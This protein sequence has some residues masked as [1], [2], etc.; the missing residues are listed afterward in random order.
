M[1]L[2]LRRC[3]FFLA[4]HLGSSVAARLGLGSPPSLSLEQSIASLDSFGSDDS[5]QSPSPDVDIT[6]ESVPDAEPGPAK[7]RPVLGALLAA[8][9]EPV[10]DAGT[11]DEL[12]GPAG[13]WQRNLN[14]KILNAYSAVQDQSDP[15]DS[16]A[17]AAVMHAMDL[18]TDIRGSEKEVQDA[19]S[20]ADSSVLLQSAAV[21]SSSGG[22]LAEI[23]RV[24]LA[25]SSEQTAQSS[26]SAGSEAGEK[27]TPGLGATPVEVIPLDDDAPMN[28]IMDWTDQSDKF[29][30]KRNVSGAKV[31]A[32]STHGK[33]NMSHQTALV[34][35]GQRQLYRHL[36]RRH[37][38]AEQIAEVEAA[39]SQMWQTYKQRLQELKNRASPTAAPTHVNFGGDNRGEAVLLSAAQLREKRYAV[40]L[41]DE[42]KY[43]DSQVPETVSSTTTVAP[44]SRVYGG[45]AL[46][47]VYHSQLTKRGAKPFAAGSEEV[48][49][50]YRQRIAQIKSEKVYQS[51]PSAP[52]TASVPP[53]P[54]VP[55]RGTV[56]LRLRSDA[57]RSSDADMSRVAK[58]YHTGEL[59]AR[60]VRTRG[61]E[62][63]QKYRRGLELM[64]GPPPTIPPPSWRKREDLSIHLS[65][66]WQPTMPPTA[67]PKPTTPAP[68]M[69]AQYRAKLQ[70]NGLD[71]YQDAD[72]PIMSRY[73][74]ELADKTEEASLE[75]EAELTQEQEE[76]LKQ[77]V[78]QKA[79]NSGSGVA[80]V[81]EA[82]PNFMEHARQVVE[83]A[84]T[85]TEKHNRKA[86][87]VIKRGGDALKAYKT[88]LRDQHIGQ[89]ADLEGEDLSDSLLQ[90]DG[91]LEESKREIAKN[92]RQIKQL[93]HGVPTL[94]PMPMSMLVALE[95]YRHRQ[96]ETQ[97]KHETQSA[98]SSL[99]I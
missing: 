44:R 30:S 24:V 31:T 68:S 37:A 97:L 99:V 35:T 39:K 26:D 4:L 93:G 47:D 6:S 92:L 86:N 81:Q 72:S 34:D 80:L 40:G 96:R 69:L 50:A 82:D 52:Q 73:R 61:S 55:A 94:P 64:Q 79:R 25:T 90:A 88:R 5:A 3:S 22:T 38:T 91:L 77:M 95:Q 7:G 84:R 16:N 17:D 9:G 78:A 27:D 87:L 19:K 32:P 18:L 8:V 75:A 36:L 14:P 66:K 43:W 89:G 12:Y 85:E 57:S 70:A 67:P 53:R 51:I 60:A 29:W 28:N 83:E 13:H 59:A 56:L 2:A 20:K 21:D 58:H 63:W 54:Q 62:I 15:Q 98:T 74:K 10:S 46:L 11:D 48:L 65:A 49:D 33:V 42:L 23:P 71:P 1:S 45:N 41:D 76:L